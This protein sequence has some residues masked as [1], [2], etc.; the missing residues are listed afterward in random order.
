M[1]YMNP[2]SCP[3]H[4]RVPLA[5]FLMIG[6]INIMALP[7]K[8]GTASSARV[9]RVLVSKK[10][11]TLRLTYHGKI[12]KEY[13]VA[14]GGVPVGAKTRQGDH[15][16]PEGVYVLD[17]RNPRSQFYRSIHISCPNAEDRARA[18]RLGVPAGGDIM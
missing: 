2:L 4:F 6:R 14:L 12:V 18:R 7:A 10:E 15:K 5:L 16:T 11:R 9:D 1:S 13:R 3:K 8:Q 17:R